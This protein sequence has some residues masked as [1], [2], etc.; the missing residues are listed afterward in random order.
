MLKNAPYMK[1]WSSAPSL[2]GSPSSFQQRSAAILSARDL[3]CI[4]WTRITWGI[5]WVLEFIHSDPFEKEEARLF[6]IFSGFLRK[7]GFNRYT[8][9]C[10]DFDG[11][12]MVSKMVIEFFLRL[13]TMKLGQFVCRLALNATYVAVV[14]LRVKKWIFFHKGT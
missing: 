3:L 6:F 13:T 5:K 9:W 2:P 10:N 4:I 11:H 1:H 14:G 8:Q 12:S 7:D